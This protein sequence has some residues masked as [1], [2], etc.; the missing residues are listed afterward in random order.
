M[1]LGPARGDAAGAGRGQPVVVRGQPVVVRA[2]ALAIFRASMES[3][4]SI[5]LMGLV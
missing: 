2:T 4:R 1:I 5:P 3:S